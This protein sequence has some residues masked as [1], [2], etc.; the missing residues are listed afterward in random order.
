[1]TEVEGRQSLPGSLP[2][3][4]PET[5]ADFRARL[6]WLRTECGSPSYTTMRNGAKRLDQAL[7][8]PATISDFVSNKHPNALP[9][10]EFVRA[11]VAGCLASRNVD[12]AV[13]HHRLGVWDDWWADLVVHS[14]QALAARPVPPVAAARPS[15]AVAAPEPS[16]GAPAGDAVPG[17]VGQAEAVPG[18]VA[19]EPPA[20]VPTRALPA[21]PRAWWRR[22][23]FAAAVGVVLGL[24]SG[25]AVMRFA[26]VWERTDPSLAYGPCAEAIGPSTVVG[27]VVLSEERGPHG[28]P[29]QDKLIQLRVQQ[30]PERGWVVWSRLAR[31]TSPLD[32]LWLDWSYLPTPTADTSEYRQCGAQPVSDGVETPALLVRDE[33]DRQRWFRACGQAPVEHRAPNRSGTFCTSWTRPRI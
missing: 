25:M 31:S 20:A 11:F 29:V 15:G 14:G 8:A 23:T 27:S 1:M 33:R 10:K 22:P 4:A 16:A 19:P 28:K 21:E 9:R 2:D 32:R 6:L 5:I 12:P 18:Q 24:V 3:G 13:I 30:H 26:P 17:Q 7:L